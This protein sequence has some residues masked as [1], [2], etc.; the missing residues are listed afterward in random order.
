[1][2]RRGAFALCLRLQCLVLAKRNT[3]SFTIYTSHPLVS[4]EVTLGKH[5][6]Q[7]VGMIPL[8]GWLHA[9]GRVYS[10]TDSNSATSFPFTL[11]PVHRANEGLANLFDEWD[12]SHTMYLLLNHI[13]STSLHN[14]SIW[15]YD[16]QN[17][18]LFRVAGTCSLAPSS[19]W[20][21]FSGV[22][23]T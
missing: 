22:I 16:I 1:M 10:S 5:P 13:Q 18:H 23:R 19:S 7:L 20:L 12:A 17:I 14:K 9:E 21:I 6:A 11:L 3:S 4:M 8:A 2:K 15:N